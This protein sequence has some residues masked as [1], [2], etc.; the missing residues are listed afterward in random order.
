[1]IQFVS[2]IEVISA[3]LLMFNEVLDEH[4]SIFFT[5]VIDFSNLQIFFTGNIVTVKKDQVFFFTSFINS[6]FF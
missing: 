4:H 2:P 5:I 6:E 3:F 1:M